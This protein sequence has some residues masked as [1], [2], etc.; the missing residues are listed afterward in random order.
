MQSD[1]DGQINQGSRQVRRWL[2]PGA[3]QAVA[4]G[5]YAARALSCCQGFP[6]RS[7]KCELFMCTCESQ[8]ITTRGSAALH[9]QRS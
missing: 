4:T 7:P 3:D 8:L 5:P 2:E 1:G 6:G 9:K